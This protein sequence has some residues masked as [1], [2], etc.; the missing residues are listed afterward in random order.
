MCIYIYICIYKYIYIYIYI[1]SSGRWGQFSRA[2]GDLN[3]SPIF[4]VGGLAN[5]GVPHFWGK[6]RAKSV[7]VCLFSNSKLNS[8]FLWKLFFSE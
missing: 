5:Q 8:I 1:L 6:Q 2:L 3:F 7:K 4:L